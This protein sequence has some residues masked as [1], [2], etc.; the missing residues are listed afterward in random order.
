MPPVPRIARNAASLLLGDVA[1]R[2]ATFALYAMVARY[3]G[4]SDLGQMALS[5]TLFYI[6]QVLAV[7]GLKTLITREV[8]QDKGRTHAYL[9]NCSLIVFGASFLSMLVIQAFA[10]LMQY[11]TQTA[12]TIFLLSLALIPFA[13]SAVCEGVFQA[14]EEMRYIAYATVPV[15]LLKAC[16]AFLVLSAGY[17]LDQVLML[18]VACHIVIMALEWWLVVRKFPPIGVRI[19]LRFARVLVRSTSTFLAID[20]VIALFG[21]LEL[22]LLSRFANET[23]VGV[24]S[25][26][27]QV[28]LPITLVIQ[29]VV[30][31]VF[32]I[33]CKRFQNADQGLK[34][35][36]EELVGLLVAVAL[37]TAIG[38]FCVAEWVLSLLYGDR[39]QSAATPL[40][41]LVWCVLLRAITAALGQLLLASQRERVTLRIV[42]IDALIDFA[43]GLILIP[44]FGVVGAAATALTTRIVDLFQHAVPVARLLPSL[45]LSRL[46]WNALLASLCMGLYLALIPGQGPVLTVL[47]GA[48]LYT[49]VIFGL[50]VWSSGGL[51][52]LRTS[53]MRLW[54]E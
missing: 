13:L 54:T 17:G 28:L 8:A 31:S 46:G 29:N 9:V 50:M 5:L 32:P 47:S 33:M 48:V 26:A 35:I 34:Q 16:G 24:F 40:R 36:T 42:S 52:Q 11:S 15:H 45:T 4:V 6:G 18:V 39:I 22:L 20:G 14:H 37:P 27:V 25:A 49:G 51:R 23:E 3:L 19:D 10:W 44:H 30:A 7:A 38:V 2:A 21:S 1:N 43:V 53:S 12:S 41:I